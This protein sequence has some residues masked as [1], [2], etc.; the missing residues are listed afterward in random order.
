MCTGLEVRTQGTSPQGTGGWLWS[1]IWV[2]L[3]SGPGKAVSFSLAIPGCKLYLHEIFKAVAGLVRNSKPA[4]KFTGL[5]QSELEYW[6]FLD[7]GQIVYRGDRREISLSF[8]NLTLLNEREKA[9]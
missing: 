9:F 2:W 3:C 5:L 4:V 8:C 7:A 1:Y 6:R